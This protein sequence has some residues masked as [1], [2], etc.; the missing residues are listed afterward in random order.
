[1][2][3]FFL[4]GQGVPALLDPFLILSTRFI[5]VF[6]PP[7]S[8]RKTGQIQRI[9]FKHDHKRN[10]TFAPFFSRQYFPGFLLNLHRSGLIGWATMADICSGAPVRFTRVRVGR[11]ERGDNKYPNLSHGASIAG[12]RYWSRFPQWSSHRCR[13]KDIPP[14]KSFPRKRFTGRMTV[15]VFPPERIS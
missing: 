4:G 15:K 11:V 5:E 12:G 8:R 3:N 1:M 14:R 9:L 6:I 7:V 13:S 2:S 10:A